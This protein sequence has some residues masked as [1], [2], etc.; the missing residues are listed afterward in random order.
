MRETLMEVGRTIPATGRLLY[1]LGRDERVEGRHRAAVAAALVY[2]VLPVD[3]LPDRIP[4]IGKLDDVVIVA[5]ALEALFEA[6]GDDVLREHWTASDGSL[7]A[8]LS[9]V[10][11][12]AGLMPKAARRMLRLGS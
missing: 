3:V 4:F 2:A 10:G 6:A 5:A 9:T 7:E 11:T 8:V 12:V 1:R